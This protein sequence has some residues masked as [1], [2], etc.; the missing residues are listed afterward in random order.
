MLEIAMSKPNSGVFQKDIARNQ[1]ISNK[2]LDQI[3]HALKASNLVSNTKGKRSGYILTRKPSEITVYDIHMAFESGICLI[4]CL[5]D[6]YHCDRSEGCLTKGF[7]GGLNNMIS[8]YFKS[9]TLDDLVNKRITI[10][11]S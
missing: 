10:E 9:V 4:E 1:S 6:N 11:N 2:Y 3:I 8:D 5:S 7:W